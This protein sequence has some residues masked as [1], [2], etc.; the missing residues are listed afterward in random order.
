M[1]RFTQIQVDELNEKIT[2]ADDALRWASENLHPAVAKASS[3]GAEDSALIEMMTRI[4]PE[5]RFFTLDTGRLPKETHEIMDKLRK[6]Y[7][8]HL[9]VLCP[10]TA[11][12]EE[13]VNTKGQN[14]FYESVEN[15]ILCCK[16]RKVNPINRILSTLDGWITGLRKE[17]S[18][19][20]NS[21]QMFQIDEQHGGILKINPIID[22]SLEQI[23]KHIKEHQIPYNA[24]LDQNYP[25][26]GCA[27]CTRA[28]KPGEDLRA[29][30]WWWESKGHSECGIHM[31]YTAKENNQ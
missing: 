7:S 17:H 31:N 11:E 16:V 18:K 27:P 5:F 4:N 3:F 1:K 20:R 29:G 2:T 8:M 14:L 23:M 10:D 26:I 9:Q 25:S 6:K 24:L 12:V 21:M 22:W 15:R 19:N 28:T 13:M 30:R